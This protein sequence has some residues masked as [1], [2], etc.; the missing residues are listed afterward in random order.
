MKAMIFAAGLGT[1]LKPFTDF[2]PKALAVV[3]GRTLLEHNITFL[4][5]S[6]ITEIVIN[7]HHFAE[8]IKAFVQNNDFKIPIHI[9][10]ETEF[11]LE[12]GGGL[13]NA[14]PFLDDNGD[15]V[16]MNADILTTL[17]LKHV[18]EA[19]KKKTPLATL[20]IS[21]RESSRALLFN[22]NNELCGW[23]NKKTNE[24]KIVRQESPLYDFA[25]SGVHIISPAIFN[26]IEL[27]GKFS[28]IDVYLSLV[29]KHKILGYDHT[30]K[31]LMDVG[32]PESIIEAE[33]YFK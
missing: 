9:S 26:L 5:K 15:F 7:V 10:D 12:T 20:C 17:D 25:F 31:L 19:H 23:Q 18:I 30:G 8:Q 3:N 32:K 16:L 6:G 33:K 14:K 11:V 24:A 1:R 28:M 2:H 22:T 13:L 4:K 27:R 21:K 29:V